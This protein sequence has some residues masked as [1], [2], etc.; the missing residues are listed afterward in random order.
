[1]SENIKETNIESGVLAELEEVVVC[2][3]SDETV[4]EQKS[5]KGLSRLKG[6][7]KIR[8]RVGVMLGSDDILGVE[9]TMF[10]II[11]N[12]IDRFKAGHGKKINIVKHADLSLEIEDFAD[13][14][15]MDWNENENAYNWELALRVLYAGENYETTMD[16]HNGQIG[17]NGLGLTS[18]QMSSEFMEVTSYKED[19]I[20]KVSFKQGRPVDK[21]T[22][23][24][25]CEDGEELFSKELGLRVLS[26]TPNTTGRTGTHIYYKPDSTVF[27]EID[28][29]L[30]WINTKTKKQA[31]VNK[32]LEIVVVDEVTETTTVHLYENGIVDYINELS[33]EPLTETSYFSC[34]GVGKDSEDRQD[35]KVSFELAFNFNNSVNIVECYH[36]SSELVHGGSTLNAIK[37]GFVAAVHKYLDDNKMYNKD[38]SKI[39]YIDIADSLTCIINS[40]SSFTSYSNQTKM[41]INNKFIQ[42][43][44]TEQIKEELQVYIA[45]NPIEAKRISE[46]I[47]ANKRS[48]ERAEKTR[49]NIRK[50]LSGNIDVV[51]RI[52]KFVDCREKDPAKRELYIVEGDS[53][54]GSCKLGRSAIFQ[55]LM[56]IRGKIL[57]CLKA[58]YDKIFSSEIIVDLIKIL[59]CGIE[60]TS[61]HNKELNTFDIT[62]LRYSKIIICTDA[63]VDGMQIRTLLLTMLYRLIP[64]LITEGKVFIAETPLYEITSKKKTYFA[65]ADAEKDK[66]VKKLGDK[67]K[68]QRS[69]G[70]GENTPDMMWETTMNP[71]T[72]KLIKVNMSDIEKADTHFELFLGDNVVNR[73]N[74]IAEH[75][76]KYVDKTEIAI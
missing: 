49:L 3:D 62:K 37:N 39:K 18:T 8:K 57:N 10:E 2:D 23:E 71:E 61:K 68:I 73:K 63:D 9:Q 26:V 17:L 1:M 56:P 42:D 21:E 13:G 33:Q 24:F 75:G 66:L 15:M 67:C 53:A 46:Q 70:L 76:H 44:V 35:Y 54:L 7:D 20:Y 28:V 43:F 14:L 29:P 25:L 34:Q 52:K 58:D 22:G 19:F 60:I 11:S 69:K 47:L 65:Y 6:A 31:V 48:R 16:T 50:Q 40:Y 36:N 27:T 4:S 12:S 51:N 45:E 32:G 38:E 72:R 30:E 74:Y 55:A 5:S 59:G 41:S 64:S